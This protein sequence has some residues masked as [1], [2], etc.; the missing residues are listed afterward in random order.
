MKKTIFAILGLAVFTLGSSSAQD[1]QKILDNYF[2]AIGQKKILSV[3]TQVSTGK[4]LQMGMEIPFKTISK[5]PDKSYMEMQIQGASVKMAFDGEKGWAIQ[6]WT[7]SNDPVELEGPELRPAK[8]LSDLDGGLWNY[9]EKGHKLELLGTEDVNGTKAYALK[10]T[11][12]DGSV[13]HYYIDTEKYLPIKVRTNM[14]IN[15]VEAETVTLMSNYTNVNGYNMP[16]KHEQSIDG[17]P[18][19]TMIFEEVKFNEQVDDAIF[20]KPAAGSSE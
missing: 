4:I 15:G 8:E 1:L 20:I 18:G 11:K 16:F 10:L 6:P 9:S 13:F 3:N 5:R 14:V 2:E 7:G 12:N 19:M 17:Q